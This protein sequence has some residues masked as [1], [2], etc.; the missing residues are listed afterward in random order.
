[1]VKAILFEHSLSS[2]TEIEKDINGKSLEEKLQILNKSIEKLGKFD[3]PVN[4][5]RLN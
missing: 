2:Y 1:M 5:L 4:T 3:N